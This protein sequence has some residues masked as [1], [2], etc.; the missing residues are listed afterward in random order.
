MKVDV[1]K[2][3]LQKST[4]MNN[5]VHNRAEA[6][7]YNRTGI[8]VSSMCAAVNVAQGMLLVLCSIPYGVEETNV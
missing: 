7:L 1:K 5:V 4:K 2:C 8:C 6:E 3:A